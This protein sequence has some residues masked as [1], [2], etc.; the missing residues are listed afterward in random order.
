MRSLK[1][2]LAAIGFSA[3]ITVLCLLL[4]DSTAL[5][6]YVTAAASVGLVLSLIFRFRLADTL[7]AVF[8]GAV[9]SCVLLLSA[10]YRHDKTVS[11]CGAGSRV[12]AVIV[13]SPSFSSENGRYY[14]V[15]SLKS[16]NSERI[17]GKI[18]FTFATL[19]D[20]EELS[21]IKAGD[22][23]SFTAYVYPIGTD[24]EETHNSFKSKSIF[25]GAYA[26]RDISTEAPRFRPPGYYAELVKKKITSTLSFYFSDDTS[27]M[28]IAIL[29]GDKSYCSDEIYLNFKRSGVAHIMAV[30]GMHLSAWV[31]VLL[32]LAGK[33]LEGFRR[34]VCLLGFLVIAFFLFIADFSPSVCR[35]AIMTGLYLIGML[36]K[37]RTDMLNS[38]GLALM[39]ILFINPYSVYSVSFQLSFACVLAIAVVALPLCEHSRLLVEKHL[40]GDSVKR[41]AVVLLS[42]I[43]VSVSIGLVT[44]PLSA[45]HFGYVSV[46]SPLTN[47][48]LVPLC[49]PL[50]LFTAAFLL[51]CRV[52]YASWLLYTGTDML[53]E[54]MLAVTG[55]IGSSPLSTVCADAEGT[56]LWVTVLLLCGVMYIF[57]RLNKRY[58]FKLTAAVLFFTVA[59]SSLYAI[60]KSFTQVRLKIIATENDSAC[61]L[62][63]DGKGIL[64][65]T[66]E[67]YGFKEEL[68]RAVEAE[69]I[70]LWAVLAE[71]DCSR[72]S[73]DILTADFSAQYV[74][75]A[76]DGAELSDEVS[77]INKGYG[78]ELTVK[79]KTL[80]VFY[81][82]YLQETKDYDIIIKYDG[83]VE[84]KDGEAYSSQ[85]KGRTATVYISNSGSV[86]IRREK[87]WLNLTKKS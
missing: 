40:R 59:F 86:R 41:I 35:A 80:A 17:S 83:T 78:A 84:C 36:I 39:C 63:A 77:L 52:P 26:L 14:A 20:G 10:Q 45:Y 58:F 72:N 21:E 60:D 81:G 19:T 56:V 34:L 54:Y 82:D 7:A 49:A 30:S 48:L 53:S 24:S 67:E 25:L 16:I 62:V 46:A 22:K 65:G 15:A 85:N 76:G 5:V 55:K 37:A 29:T 87:P 28:L 68:S 74:L 73:L 61:L 33:A 3:L 6:V 9:L 8:I 27:G 66:D 47:L 69:N 23:I 79:G 4:F 31:A 50:M 42:Y 70:S 13:Q 57:H 12:E 11:L 64:I 71:N 38:L 32:F 1:R 18:R 2:P 51:L 44:F 43:I 75:F